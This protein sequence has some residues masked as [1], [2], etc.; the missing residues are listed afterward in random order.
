MGNVKK[1]PRWT[2][3]RVPEAA[4]G[5]GK[6]RGP[7]LVNNSSFF[8]LWLARWVV[9]SPRRRF[10]VNKV[11]IFQVAVRPPGLSW[12]SRP[13]VVANGSRFFQVRARPAPHA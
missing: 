10:F 8:H 6:T 1:R 13:V 4:K 7:F 2:E 9:G 3:D 11:R 12:P 5:S